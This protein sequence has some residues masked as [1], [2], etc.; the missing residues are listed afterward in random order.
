VTRHAS[1]A[2]FA[3]LAVLYVAAGIWTTR[4]VGPTGDE[5]YYL[6]AADSLVRGEG[7]AHDA[8]WSSIASSGYDP[9]DHLADLPRQSSPSLRA[10]GHFPLHDLGLSLLLGLPFAIGGR[11]LAVACVGVA[12][13]A[14]I[15]VAH[16]AAGRLVGPRAA[17]GGAL[18]GG[19]S[20]PALTYSGQ[21]FPDSVMAL[22][23]AAGV[24]ALVG[25]APLWAGAIGI[26]SLPL[27]H[28]RGWPLAIALLLAL[29][30]G[31]AWRVRVMLAAP[32]LAIVVGSSLVDLAVYGVALPHAGFLLFFSARPDTSVLT[33]AATTPFGVLGLFV[34]RAFGL[35]PAAPVSLLA[36]V[37]AGV[38]IRRRLALP[39]LVIP[40]LLLASG[41]DWTGGLSPQ[42][43]YLA[44][45][46][47]L[48]VVFLSLGLAAR[49]W[50]IA[51]VVL[52]PLTAAMSAVYVAV[53]GIR[54]DSFGVPPFADRTLDRAVGAHLSGIFPL[55]GT[56]GATA[57]LLVLW[58]VVL[59]LAVAAGA[60]L[61]AVT[62]VSSSLGT[63]GRGAH[64]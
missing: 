25:A 26:A 2:L 60:G 49:R 4:R 13:A 42:A 41:V 28:L 22:A 34:D 33:Y 35:L 20:V 51:V 48:L 38:A 57:G 14:A 15:A 32:L 37:G 19:L 62:R 61:A 52:A 1:Y 5:P 63:M 24:A 46:V 40:Y 43:R 12:M 53:P 56:G 16:R 10:P 27:L 21:L 50:R 31:R 29:G 18:L 7:F 11:A 3:L 6:L 36:F 64:H 23:M 45:V 54:Y 47:P 55:L 9:G 17:I 30:W 44:P 39:L 59:V 58:A 8:R